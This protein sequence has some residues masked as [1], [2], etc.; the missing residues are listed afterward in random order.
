MQPVIRKYG[1]KIPA[2]LPISRMLSRVAVVPA[3]M[4]LR[5]W[6]GPIKDQGSESSCTANAGTETNEWIIRKYFPQQGKLIFSPQYTYAKELL[7]QGDFPRD[8]GSDGTTMCGT[9]I[10]NGCCELSM[11]PYV[12]GQILK[13]TAAQDMNAAKHTLGAFH[14][15]TGSG[16]AA[17]VLGDLVPW[18]ISMG[19]TVYASFESDTVAR[20][21]IYNPLI[22]EQQLGGHEVKA[23]GYDLGISPTLRPKGCPPAF[24]FQNSWGADW[25]LGGYFWAPIAVLNASDTDLKIVHSGKPWA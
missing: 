16:V 11:Y 24:L 4:D 8:E 1:R 25:G 7:A 20:T 18:P 14:G 3:V 12:A 22:T 6:D 17:S 21:G 19:F 5:E 10:V 13:P 15:L 9:L 23:S 2:P